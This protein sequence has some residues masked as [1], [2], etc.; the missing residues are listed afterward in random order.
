[1]YKKVQN[2]EFPFLDIWRFHVA[3]KPGYAI[4]DSNLI[5]IWIGMITAAAG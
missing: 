4:H 2:P 5:Q 3:P 1:L